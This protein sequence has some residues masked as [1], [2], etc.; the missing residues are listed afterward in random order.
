MVEIGK[1]DM[2]GSAK[3]DM[4]PF[5][6]NRNYC[7]IDLDQMASERPALM[8]K[9]VELF[10]AQRLKPIRSAEVVRASAVA[11]AFRI[12]Q[13]S[14]HI[15]KIV[16]QLRND[17]GDLLMNDVQTPRM[18]PVV[19]DSSAAYLLV[20]GL[21]G[22]GRSFARH[23]IQQGAR[24]LVFMSRTAADSHHYPFIREIE[25][26][27]CT[28]QCIKGT[29]VQQADIDRAIDEALAPV[30]GIINMT[31]SLADEAFYRMDIQT[32]N[33]SVEPKTK[34]TWN[35]FEVSK[36]RKL[37]L[38]FLVLISS[39]SA[40]VGQTGQANYTSANAFLDAFS[41]YA[42]RQGVPCTTVA[43]GVL[44]DVGALST[45]VELL[46]K[47]QGAGWRVNSESEFITTVDTAIQLLPSAGQVDDKPASSYVEAVDKSRFVF[48]LSPSFPLDH[49]NSSAKLRA[50][51]R[52][53][54]YHNSKRQNTDSV[55]KENVLRTLL[56]SAKRE[57]AILE[58]DD[59]VNILAIEI[60]KKLS[61][62]L[63]LPT[64]NLTAAMKTGEMGLDSMVA[65]EMVSW[66][67]VTFGLELSTLE[68]VS[69]GTLHALGQR[70]AT[71][72]Q[73]H[74]A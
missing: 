66:W 7:C 29:V 2:L 34:G 16:V 27:G 23:M 50:D 35:I 55:E 47:L 48:G 60:G 22:L 1:R 10:T 4:R 14:K 54:V 71:D 28:V 59:N 37:N 63:L 49:P 26:M 41:Q 20:G 32:W 13:Q 40:A 43:F 72:L 5:S 46:R 21:G 12:M 36:R 70:A 3:L 8:N 64:D 38:D 30:K 33:L 15:G 56:T 51:A 42:S 67:K 6:D 53:A 74:Y 17:K 9:M 65:V 68:I 62:L 69:L 52:M 61:S 73:C 45:N 25:S 57:P 18:G 19:L 44:G 11:D 31:M 24:N 58:S 39:L